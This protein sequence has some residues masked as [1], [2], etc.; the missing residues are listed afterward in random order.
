MRARV[1]DAGPLLFL[2]RLFSLKAELDRLAGMGFWISQALRAEALKEAGPALARFSLTIASPLKRA[3]TTFVSSKNLPFTLV[4]PLT[5][6]LGRALHQFRFFWSQDTGKR[7]EFSTGHALRRRKTQLP[8]EGQNLQLQLGRQFL[9]FFNDLLF[10]RGRARY[11]SP[12]QVLSTHYSTFEGARPRLRRAADSS[13]PDLQRRTAHGERTAN[14]Y[15][16][17]LTATAAPEKAPPE[18]EV[19]CGIISSPGNSGLVIC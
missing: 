3:T 7:E 16:Y 8:D 6:F 14:V 9:Q 17:S 13:A 5:A 15:R 4:H 10:N 11:G 1:V 2:A 12:H 18:G 19:F